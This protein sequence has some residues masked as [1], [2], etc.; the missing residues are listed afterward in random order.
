MER[1]GRPVANHC[2]TYQAIFVPF[3]VLNGLTDVP[4]LLFLLPSFLCPVSIIMQGRRQL[5]K[6][7]A[8]V[9]KSDNM[10]KRCG[11]KSLAKGR[12]YLKP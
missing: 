1:Q 9:G 6:F 5:I 11:R 4:L 3:V 8:G 12:P 2:E 7:I 10:S